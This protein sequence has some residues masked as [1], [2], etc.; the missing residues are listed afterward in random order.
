MQTRGVG[1]RGRGADSLLRA[2]TVA[3]VALVAFVELLRGGAAGGEYGGDQGG[4][5]GEGGGGGYSQC[6]TWHGVE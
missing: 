2:R 1:G 5:L 4:A 3:L 6:S